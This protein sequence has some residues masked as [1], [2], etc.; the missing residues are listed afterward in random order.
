MIPNYF[1][2]SR[3]ATPSIKGSRNPSSVVKHGGG[4]RTGWN[5]KVVLVIGFIANYEYV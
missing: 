5:S 1:F 2:Y 3:A 4:S